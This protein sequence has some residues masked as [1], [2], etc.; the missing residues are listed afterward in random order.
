MNYEFKKCGD[1]TSRQMPCT[2]TK[3]STL[4]TL[5]FVFLYVSLSPSHTPSLACLSVRSSHRKLTKKTRWKNTNRKKINRTSEK[6]YNNK[7]RT[8][9]KRINLLS[10]MESVDPLHTFVQVKPD[11]KVSQHIEA[12]VLN[13][14]VRA[15]WRAL[16]IAFENRNPL[17][18]YISVCTRRIGSLNHFHT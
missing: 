13:E 16:T 4:L 15:I 12:F 8:L 7:F 2:N 1:I 5:L 9:Q 10:T 11:I 14:H 18:T 3:C 6:N 17:L